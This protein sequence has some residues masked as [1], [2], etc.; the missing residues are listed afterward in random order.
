MTKNDWKLIR[1][2]FALWVIQ[3]ILFSSQL[4]TQLEL[5]VFLSLFPEISIFIAYAELIYTYGNQPVLFT[6]AFLVMIIKDILITKL[7]S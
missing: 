3:I 6:L 1:I 2:I 4:K 7:F 5:T